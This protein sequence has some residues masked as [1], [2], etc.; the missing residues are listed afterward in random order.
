M[1]PRTA[2]S[3]TQLRLRLEPEAAEPPPVPG[4]EALLRA[5]ADLLLA[6]LGGG[7]AD[8]K[9]REGEDEPEDHA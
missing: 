2:P 7:E 5:L 1:R 3:R 8:A 4:S 6:A 9:R